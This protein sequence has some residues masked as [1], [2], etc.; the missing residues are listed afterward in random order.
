MTSLSDILSQHSQ[1]CFVLFPCDQHPPFYI[2]E[3]EKLSEAADP[4]LQFARYSQP[5][6]FGVKVKIYN[7]TL[8]VQW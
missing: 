1:C 4:S 6:V 8:S 5:L 3:P 7:I 2:F